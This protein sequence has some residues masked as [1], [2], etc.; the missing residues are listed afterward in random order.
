M[1]N[2]MKKKKC[3]TIQSQMFEAINAV[4]LRSITLKHLIL[5]RKINSCVSANMLKENLVGR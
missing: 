4:T 2:R 5:R 1:I 3:V